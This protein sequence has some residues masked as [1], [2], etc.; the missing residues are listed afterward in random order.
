MADTALILGLGALAVFA[1]QKK[2]S[3]AT[4]E[5]QV[6]TGKSTQD[7]AAVYVGMKYSAAQTYGT[8]EQLDPVSSRRVPRCSFR[9]ADELILFWYRRVGAWSGAGDG[10]FD[11]PGQANP[12]RELTRQWVRLYNVVASRYSL[13]EKSVPGALSVLIDAGGELTFEE[14]LQF[15]YLIGSVA[16]ELAGIE[17]FP[18]QDALERA[19]ESV[20]EAFGEAPATVGAWLGAASAWAAGTVA[21]VA[22]GVAGGVATGI[23]DS[24]LGIVIVAGIALAALWED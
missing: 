23:L 19:W 18:N 24:P 16:G 1:T 4:M 6:A 21:T 22:A 14:A 5:L 3:P 12:A 9:A 13:P 15:W 10:M 11:S 8:F 17:S 2:K 7:W 20:K